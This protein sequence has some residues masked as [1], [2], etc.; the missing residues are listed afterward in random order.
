M[1]RKTIQRGTA[2]VNCCKKIWTGL[3]VWTLCGTALAF[4]PQPSS[5]Q[6]VS[7]DGKYRL[8]MIS[9]LDEEEDTG[10]D[11]DEIKAIRQT[12]KQSGVHRNDG[13][14]QLLY[15]MEYL[16]WTFDAEFSPCGKYLVMTSSTWEKTSRWPWDPV[17]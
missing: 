13:S 14:N 16:D 15:P 12:Y 5:W 2:T 1:K 4:L 11:A 9:P 10:P 3:A 8:V 6:K 7:V 17:G